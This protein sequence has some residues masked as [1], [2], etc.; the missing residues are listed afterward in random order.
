MLML[1]SLVVVEC[2]GSDWL[3]DEHG[4]LGVLVDLRLLIRIV[5]H[6]LIALGH[7]TLLSQILLLI[8]LGTGEALRHL[9]LIHHHVPTVFLLN[10][11]R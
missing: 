4:G 11:G 7:S 8:E 9:L 10:R 2:D 3:V 6:G 1:I 5:Q